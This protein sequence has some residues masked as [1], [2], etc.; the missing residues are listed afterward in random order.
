MAP[1]PV[2]QDGT[3]L[4]VIT[5]GQV[6]PAQLDQIRA[7]SSHCDVRYVGDE[8]ELAA[9][10]PEADVL[11]GNVPPSL[12]TSAKRLRWLHSWGAGV[13]AGLFPDLINSDLL[14]TC[15]KGNG[16]IPLA[17]HVML[18]MLMLARDIPNKLRAQREHL[19]AHAPHVELTGQTLGVIGLGNSGVDLARK[20][21]A[22]HMKVIGLRRT[23]A[24]CPEVDHIY[25]IVRLHEFLAASD[26]VAVTCPLTPETRHMLGE[27]EFRSMR[28]TSYYINVSR[29][30]VADPAALEQ[31]L[32]SA[33]IAGAGLDA[34][35]EEPLP[36]DSP[37]WDLPNTII[38]PHY[39]ATTPLTRQRAVDIFTA[40]LRRFLAGEPLVN[41]V[42]KVA[43]Y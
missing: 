35:E 20:A 12:F 34:H 33:W 3:L 43:G 22:F 18:L 6:N 13:D 21:K 26:F 27:A 30:A 24:P 9:L 41:V 8:A 37:F 10:L 11:S 17:E 23:Q 38:T 15:S 4:V 5:G 2:D 42:N 25:P 31:A 1:L 14:M 29:G 7:V 40:N 36:P 28:P 39:G 16:G 32:R 19:W